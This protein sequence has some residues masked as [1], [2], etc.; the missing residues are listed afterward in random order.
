MS[1][2]KNKNLKLPNTKAAKKARQKA[3]KE[4][5]RKQ[6]EAEKIQ[7]LKLEALRKEALERQI[8]E[9][10]RAKIREEKRIQKEA[11]KKKKE[12]EKIS[13][14]QKKKTRKQ[15]KKEKTKAQKI[16]ASMKARNA[17]DKKE[18]IKSK[19]KEPVYLQFGEQDIS[20]SNDY[21]TAILDDIEDKTAY[22]ES[23]NRSAYAIAVIN[24]FSQLANIITSTGAEDFNDRC[25]QTVGGKTVYTRIMELMY[26]LDE[27]YTPGYDV[28]FDNIIGEI[29]ALLDPLMDDVA[30]VNEAVNAISQ[31]QDLRAVTAI[32]FED[33]IEV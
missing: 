14:R 29:I 13:R 12:E 19:K 7:E 20:F 27:Y 1:K 5:Q 21:Y 15:K 26:S 31:T 22:W 9:L 8:E 2:K 32:A 24:A 10:R 11:E 3:Y 4:A 23:A 30:E 16:N 17:E 25:G 6:A 18:G 28:G 33:Y